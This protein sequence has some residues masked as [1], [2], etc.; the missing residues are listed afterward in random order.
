MGNVL[1]IPFWVEKL[2]TTRCAYVTLTKPSLD[3]HKI[4]ACQAK[5]KSIFFH[6]DFGETTFMYCAVA[7]YK[8]KSVVRC[9]MQ[10]PE[11]YKQRLI[12]TLPVKL[13]SN[14]LSSFLTSKG[15][16][17]NPLSWHIMEILQNTIQAAS[18]VMSQL[19]PSLPPSTDSISTTHFSS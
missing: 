11:T 6:W 12:F 19:P 4:H 18:Q 15:C 14:N 2:T 10:H 8:R 7:F 1:Q 5:T 9:Q 16:S 17:P 3:K 13:R